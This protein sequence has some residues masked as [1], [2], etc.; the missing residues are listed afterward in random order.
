LRETTADRSASAGS[1]GP[2]AHQADRRL[3]SIAYFGGQGAGTDALKLLGW[4][5]A[6]LVPLALGCLKRHHIRTGPKP[7]EPAT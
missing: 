7:D 6:G 1:A 3:C 4:L 2:A 5:A